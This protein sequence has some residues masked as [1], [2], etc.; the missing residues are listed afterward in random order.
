MT[1]IPL[2]WLQMTSVSK[3]KV[4]L[5]GAKISGYWRQQ[6]VMTALKASPEMFPTEYF[7]DEPCITGML[8]VKS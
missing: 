1:E 3:T 4:R 7:A 6:K 5:K 8:A 2:I